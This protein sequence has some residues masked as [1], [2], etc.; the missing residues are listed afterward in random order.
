MKMRMTKNRIQTILTPEIRSLKPD[1][2]I[3][4]IEIIVGIG[5]IAVALGG[6]IAAFTLY[7]RAGTGNTDTI[8][9]A[10]LLEEG[11]EALRYLRGN[12]WSANIVPLSTSTAYFLVLSG[13][14]W[15]ATTSDMLIDNVFRRS[16]TLNDVFRREIDDDIIASTSPD[17]K[18]FDP[19]IKHVIISVEN[20][21]TS[22]IMT[23]ETYLT[24][25]F[26]N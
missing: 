7:F 11:V 22:D 4:L 23:A 2:G 19:D 8:E 16:V 17:T 13:G 6:I 14:T 10:Y 5:V 12:S 25:L 3:G 20:A 18:Y 15:K 9:A 1:R 24:N 26:K 21:S